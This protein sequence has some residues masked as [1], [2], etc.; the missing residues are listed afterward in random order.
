MRGLIM[1]NQVQRLLNL[2]IDRWVQ[3]ILSLARIG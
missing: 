2:V 3:R 1:S